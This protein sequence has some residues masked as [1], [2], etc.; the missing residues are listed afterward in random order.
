MALAVLAGAGLGWW[1]WS[2]LGDQHTD[3]R[4][5]LQSGDHG[6]PAGLVMDIDDQ[7]VTGRGPC[8]GFGADWS[9]DDGASE[10]VGNAMGCSEPV[11]TQEDTYF[12]LL[13]AETVQ[14]EGDELRLISNDQTLVFE[15]VT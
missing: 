8:N 15:R 1:A 4:W 11:V 6:V 5:E 12:D 9:D 7:R 10:L 3:G 13:S 14:V 2:A